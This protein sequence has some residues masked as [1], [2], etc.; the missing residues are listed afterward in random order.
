[1]VEWQGASIYAIY[2]PPIVPCFAQNPTQ[3]LSS[4]DLQLLLGLPLSGSSGGY[5]H[6]T[7]L[8]LFSLLT[9]LSSNQSLPDSLSSER[10]EFWSSG[11]LRGPPLDLGVWPGGG[12]PWS[13]DGR[14]REEEEAVQCSCEERRSIRGPGGGRGRAPCL[15]HTATSLGCS[16][17]PTNH[18]HSLPSQNPLEN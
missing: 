18:S 16:A 3:A 4:S 11:A 2:P 6:Q 9:I 12:A 5:A 1:M 10:L 8:R 14:S 17:R 15:H 13:R 7:T